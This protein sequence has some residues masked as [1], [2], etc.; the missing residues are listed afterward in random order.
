MSTQAANYPD[1]V[2]IEMASGVSAFT[3]DPFVHMLL[4]FADGSTKTI[5]QFTPAD[6]R[7]HGLHVIETAEA[8]VHDAA[9]AA[10]MRDKLN[11]EPEVAAQAIADLREYRKD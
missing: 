4:V 3:G 9:M 5:N 6:A 10:W 11:A 2:R 1:P 7:Q 8:A